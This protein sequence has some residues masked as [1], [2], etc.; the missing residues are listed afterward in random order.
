MTTPA[1]VLPMQSVNVTST[2]SDW[3]SGTATNCTIEWNFGDSG[4]AY[5][6]MNGFNAAHVYT[7]AGTYTITLTI[8]TPDGHVGVATEQVTVGADNRPTVEIAAGQAIPTF[9]SNTRYLF[10]AGG[11]WDI[12]SSL[13]VAGLQ[14]VFIG[15]YGNGAQPVLVADNASVGA[16]IGINASTSGLTVQGITFDS[17]YTTDDSGQPDVCDIAGNDVAFI[18][19]TVL[20]IDTA[21]NMNSLPSNVLIEGCNSPNNDLC[22]YFA[23]IQGSEIVLVGNSVDNSIDQ[24]DIRIGGPPAT[25]DVNISDNNFNKIAVGTTQGKNCI[26]MQWVEYDY[27][28]GNTVT[29]GPIQTGPIGVQNSS[30]NA[31]TASCLN[32][33]IEDNTVNQT[34]ILISPESINTMIQNNVVNSDGSY[35]FIVDSTQTGDGF[36]WQVQNL[37]LMN[38]T[39]IDTS[40]EGG[41]LTINDGDSS[42]IVMD[43]NLFIDPNLII[44]DNQSAYVYAPDMSS[45]SQIQDNVWGTYT[46]PL[47]PWYN[48]GEFFVG[49]SQAIES[50]WLTPQ[51]WESLTLGS[52]ASPTGDVFMNVTL[53]STYSIQVNGFT[54]GANLP[55]S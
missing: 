16:I 55:N 18:G 40:A 25:I 52:G 41:F 34:I 47:N 42:N 15:S 51:Q 2:S 24:A 6:V 17:V 26:T 8:I 20:D 23:W 27:I 29:G 21:F 36:N 35:G 38:N 11:T 14:N 49:S 9:Q 19:D 31:Q 54:A 10:Q 4:S 7:N 30:N 44:G 39:V 53:G 12:G 22:G 50:D 46:T 48:G 3:G 33:V 28:Y 43:N 5:D 1:T 13:S 45:F 37:W 32:S